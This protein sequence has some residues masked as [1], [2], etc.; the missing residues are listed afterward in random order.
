MDRN[1]VPGQGLGYPLQVETDPDV[2]LRL[3]LLPGEIQ[4]GDLS[5]S[6][7]EISQFKLLKSNT[8]F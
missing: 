6:V 8:P 7:G 3:C 2:H 5:F 1:S 4:P